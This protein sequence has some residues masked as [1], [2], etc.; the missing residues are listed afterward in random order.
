MGNHDGAKD[1]KN[2]SNDLQ[3]IASKSVGKSVSFAP[4]VPEALKMFG[5]FNNA[6]RSPVDKQPNMKQQTLRWDRDSKIGISSKPIS[7]LPG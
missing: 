3:T 5:T 2:E 7:A 1:L 6:F 4:V